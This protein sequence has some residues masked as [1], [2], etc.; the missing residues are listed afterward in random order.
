MPA[1]SGTPK[2][3]AAAADASWPAPLD[4]A[5]V[6]VGTVAGAA[7]CG[8]VSATL[9]GIGAVV[10]SLAGLPFFGAGA[11]G[12][13]IAGSTLFGGTLMALTLRKP[14]TD[15]TAADAASG[16]DGIKKFLPNPPR[17]AASMVLA[18][19]SIREGWAKAKQAA[20][21]KTA[22]QI[23]G[24]SSAKMGM[25]LGHGAARTTSL[26]LG[27]ALGVSAFNPLIGVPLGLVGG[28]AASYVLDKPGHW[29][30][31][32]AAQLAGAAGGALA[33]H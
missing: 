23:G 18:E 30:G 15:T 26:V 22:A 8:T 5:H 12:A 28:F 29:L 4:S 21:V 13:A 33:R 10:A 2:P 16:R 32:A 3:A 1:G 31:T 25:I 11:I 6:A 17:D 9:C 19:N 24:A 14:M 7:L 20:D 27:V